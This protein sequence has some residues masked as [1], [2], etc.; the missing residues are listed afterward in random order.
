MKEEYTDRNIGYCPFYLAEDTRTIYCSGPDEDTR[1]AVC[2]R[3]EEACDAYKEKY[4]DSVR[5]GRCLMHIANDLSY[6]AGEAAFG[7]ADR[8]V[9]LDGAFSV[10]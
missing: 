9:Y 7:R 6:Y 1:H 4:C 8:R 2:F 10:C 5:C 3:S